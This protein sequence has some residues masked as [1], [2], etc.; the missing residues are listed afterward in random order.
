MKINEL[1]TESY[2]NL[3]GDKSIDDKNKYK[4]EVYD[5]LK[6]TYETAGG[7]KGNGLDSPESMVEKIPFWKLK[8]KNGKLVAGALYK[9]KT[10]R[11]RVAIFHDN[12]P[13]G[14]SLAVQTMS[15]DIKL[16][17]AYVEVSKGSLQS[18]KKR[19]GLDFILKNAIPIDKVKQVSKDE[20]RPV[21]DDDAEV[22]KHPELK[23]FF[24]KRTI[25]GKFE[26]KIMLGKIGNSLK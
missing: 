8:F 17:R 23:D 12:T 16:G 19:N 24:Y 10:G 5:L 26:T 9:D 4:N 18:L 11:K 25:N 22:L 15:D 6:K 2:V 7:I 21:D 20:I 13:E 14:K 3:V 1:L